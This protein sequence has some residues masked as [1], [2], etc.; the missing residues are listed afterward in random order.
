MPLEDAASPKDTVSTDGKAPVATIANPALAPADVTGRTGSPPF[1][2]PDDDA[3][4]GETLVATDPATIDPSAYVI[5]HDRLNPADFRLDDHEIQKN[6]YPFF[7]VLQQQCPVMRTEVAGQ[8]TFAISRRDDITK[9]LL[10]HETFSSRTTPLPNMLFADPPLHTKWRAMVSAMFTRPQVERFGP[11]IAERAAA[12]LPAMLDKGRCDI[13]EDFAS[14]LTMVMNGQMLGL[15]V[16]DVE[17]LAALTNVQMEFIMAVRS[18]REPSPTAKR[19]HQELIQFVT[20]IVKGRTFVPGGV[21]EVL[22]DRFEAGELSEVECT[23]FAVMLLTAGHTTTTKLIG[24]AIYQLIGRPQHLERIRNEEDG[25]VELYLEEVLRTMPSFQRNVRLTTR[26]T[27]IGGEMIPA[28]TLVR[29]ML[30]AANHDAEY[31]DDPFRFDPDLKRRSH[32]AFGHGI[33]T[34]IGV[35]LARLEATTALTV[36]ARHVAGITLDAERPPVM[37]SGGTFNE[38]GYDSLPVV[39]TRR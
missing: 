38:F 29:F 3:A 13:I 28:G 1:L 8:L 39:L 2:L 10:D 16:I 33:H 37:V 18:G 36:F 24:S 7:P 20:D 5:A 27:E 12:L 21:I 9:A 34:C 25:F 15:P 26:D 14:P 31:Y 35:W 19:A 6:P 11:V 32:L 23:H 22:A 30:G 17:R 4:M